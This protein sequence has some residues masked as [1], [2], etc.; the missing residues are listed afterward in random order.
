M[1]NIKR[2]NGAIFSAPM[3]FKSNGEV[4]YSSYENYITK[5]VE[6]EGV[7]VIFAMA[8]NT[9]FRQLSEEEIIKVSKITCDLANSFEKKA[10]IGHPYTITSK[11]LSTFCSIV[12]Q[13]KPYA[14]SILYPERYY[15]MTKPLQDF[16]NIPKEHNIKVLVHEQKLVSGFNGKLI[17]WPDNLINCILK[18]ENVIAVKEDSKDNN[19][20]SKILKLSEKYN[21][22]VIVAGGGKRRVKELIKS[23][24]LKCWLN[25]SLMLFPELAKIIS[26]AYLRNDVKLIQLYEEKIEIPYFDEF[27]SKVGWHVGHKAALHILGYC[28][29][30]ERSPMPIISNENIEKYKSLILDLKHSANEI[31]KTKN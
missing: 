20:T 21:F 26:E 7:E 14:I 1:E 27:I 24:N 2:L 18:E 17:D 9:R 5:C 30:N 13:F 19:M 28:E 29:L 15:G 31:M 3:F 12:S 8:Y 23:D 11:E 4:D 10:I 16:F 25:G 6:S 22:D